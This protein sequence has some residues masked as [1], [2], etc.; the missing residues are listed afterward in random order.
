MSTMLTMEQ[1]NLF[2]G[3][4]DPSKSKHLTISELKL[5]DLA[6]TFVDHNAGGSRVGIEIG[7]GIE[8]LTAPFKL[9]GV[10]PDMIKHFG[11]GTRIF[12]NFTAYGVLLDQR[13]G[14]RKEAKALM[15]GRLGR[16]APDTFQ[17]GDL[18]GFDY[19]IN[20]IMH[21]ELHIDGEELIFFDFFTNGWRVGGVDQ[22]SDINR[23][24]RI[25]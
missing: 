10:D 1:V 17:K 24:L 13:T 15:N 18:L 3:D 14:V 23:I 20:S 6:E 21:Y 11:L 8:K 4:A 5:P 19:A 2:A 7:M 12:E 22:N 25:G 9:N 16:A